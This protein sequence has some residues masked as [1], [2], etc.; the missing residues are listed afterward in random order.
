MATEKMTESE[1]EL[2]MDALQ[3]W[4]AKSSSEQAEFAGS[5]STYC[6]YVIGEGN[7]QILEKIR[8]QGG[9]S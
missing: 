2:V 8:N 5:F 3:S 7:P 9:Q 1:N 6:H 4:K